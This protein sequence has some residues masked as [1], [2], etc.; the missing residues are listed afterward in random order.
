VSLHK[1]MT[2]QEVLKLLPVDGEKAVSILYERYDYYLLVAINRI[3][4]DEN[5]ARDLVQEVFVDIWRRRN[6]LKITTS[7]KAYLRT[8]ARNKTLNYVRDQKMTFE[9]Q[10]RHSDIQS[11]QVSA[12]DQLEADELQAIIDRAIDELPERC[13]LV[14]SLSRFEEL[15][16]KEIAEQ[17]DISTKTVENQISKAL[18]LLRNSL[19]PYIDKGMLGILFFMWYL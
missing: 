1:E 17:L 5:I 10:E 11:N 6:D 19:A 8:A 9:D 3:I 12:N 4:P 13:R 7:V 14:F 16:Y 2:D 15:S 18:K